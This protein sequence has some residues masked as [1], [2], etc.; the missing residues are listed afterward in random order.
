MVEYNVSKKEYVM[1]VTRYIFQSP[2]SN[3]FQV[4]RPDTTVKPQESSSEDVS[5]LAQVA[6]TSLQSAQNFQQ[7]QIKE[8]T[9]TVNTEHALDVYT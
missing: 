1:D 4:G 2:Y 9:P 6:N 8:V 3:K 7:T 5:K